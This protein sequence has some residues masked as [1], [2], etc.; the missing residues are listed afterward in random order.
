ML[1]HYHLSLG[2]NLGDRKNHIADAI[3]KLSLSK[4]VLLLKVSPIYKTE[5]L[6]VAKQNSFFNIVLKVSTIM[7]PDDLHSFT[8]N[9]EFKMGRKKTLIRNQARTIDIDILT[10]NNTCFNSNNLIIP[11]PR[12][13][14]RKFVLAPFNDIDSNFII[15]GNN[16]TVSELLNVVKD[17]SKIVKLHALK[18]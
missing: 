12:I 11:H 2:S 3:S 18:I 4:D 7:N 16:K 8:K 13:T 6:Y 14:E 9:I 10:Y 15:P 17:S 5:P 1:N